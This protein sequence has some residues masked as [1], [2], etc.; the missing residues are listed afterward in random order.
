MIELVSTSVLGGRK[1]VPRT[2][3]RPLLSLPPS[4]PSEDGSDF[5]VSSVSA[6]IAV[7]AHQYNFSRRRR[8]NAGAS[9]RWRL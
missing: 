3:G 6:M 9:A 1:C 5:A 8:Q 7:H 2:V 4:R